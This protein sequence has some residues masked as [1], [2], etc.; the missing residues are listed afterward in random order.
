[1]AKD[2]KLER[3]CIYSI[4]FQRA[5]RL[6]TQKLDTLSR[7][8]LAPAS[9]AT[10]FKVYAKGVRKSTRTFT[11]THT[12]CPH[13]NQTAKA[14]RCKQVQTLYLEV[15]SLSFCLTNA[16]EIIIIT[17]P[18]YNGNTAFKSSQEQKAGRHSSQW[19]Q[20][21]STRSHLG[22]VHVDVLCRLF[23]LEQSSAGHGRFQHRTWNV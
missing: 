15:H 19:S 14:Q 13:S 21:F 4:Y 20:L 7:L 1:M 10:Y 3:Y 18:I 22:F 17:I 11:G 23:S 8:N 9:R 12:V 2:P 6:D 16:N 5:R